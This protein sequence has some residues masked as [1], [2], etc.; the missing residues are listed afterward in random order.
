MKIFVAGGTGVLGRRVVSQ[1]VQ[2]GHEVVGLS[3]SSEDDDRLATR[4]AEPRR[5]DLFDREGMHVLSVD[6]DAIINL[7]SVVSTKTRTRIDDRVLHDKMRSE[8]T[9]N[10]VAAA[11][12]NNC[13][14]FIQSSV[15]FLYG[16]RHG[17]WVDESCPPADDLPEMVKSSVEMEKLVL[18]A[19]AH[20]KLPAIILRFGSI[21]AHDSRST[22]SMYD[23]ISKGKFPLIERGNSYWNLVTAD[24]AARA[25]TA[26]VRNRK[27]NLG[28][29][30]NIC[31]DEPVRHKDLIEFLAKALG[32]PKP[33]SIPIFLAEQAIGEHTVHYL[34]Q[35]A[36][37][38]NRRAKDELGWNPIYTTF[39]EGHEAIMEL[40]RAQ[41]GQ[42][43]ESNLR[44]LA[45]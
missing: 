24:D 12:R 2:S 26:A 9:S 36:R 16:R 6:C 7:T 44:P 20:H 29:V 10:L 34:L 5:G 21:Y 28:K 42:R 8:G 30:F 39:R 37:C 41:D 25:V 14:L 13:K 45:L 40:W 19:M 38:T 22:I 18:D 32:A 35:S 43:S 3:R 31:D 27:A 15:T 11:V 1:L 4:G 33:G 23:L 17:E